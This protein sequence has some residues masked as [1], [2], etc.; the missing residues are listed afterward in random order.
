MG[1]ISKQQIIEA[2]DLKMEKVFV[3][4]WADGD[5]EAY[6]MVKGMTAGMK[7]KWE[8]SLI[9]D[10]DPN[11]RDLTDY[12][13]KIC[14]YCMVDDEGNYLFSEADAP[15]LSGK[16]AATL[17]RVFD[18]AR[19]LSGFTKEAVKGMEKNSEPVPNE[20]LPSA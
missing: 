7:D 4:E 12:R 8:M 20:S 10:N 15:I 17:D 9:F 18:V 2:K 11:K 3:P 1:C 5:P 19:K 16:N 13:A 14:I 6:V